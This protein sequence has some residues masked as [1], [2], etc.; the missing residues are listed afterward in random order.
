M[1]K[2]EL[3]QRTK[4]FALRA[5]K[6]VNALPNTI[7]GRNIGSQLFRSGTSV[8]ANYR[9]ACRSRSTAEFLAKLNTVIEEADESLFWIEIIKESKIIDENRLHSLLKEADEIVAIM[10]ASRKSVQKNNQ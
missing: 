8:A 5:I 1:T 9:A 3:K 10:V 4:N 2:E 6:L 7:A